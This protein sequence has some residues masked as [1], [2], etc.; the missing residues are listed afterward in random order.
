M[1]AEDSD[2]GPPHASPRSDQIVVSPCDLG[3]IFKRITVQQLAALSADLLM[4]FRVTAPRHPTQPRNLVLDHSDGTSQS[5]TVPAGAGDY[6]VDLSHTYPA[7]GYT[8]SWQDEYVRDTHYTSTT[9][10]WGPMAHMPSV[11]DVDPGT[12]TVSASE[13][14]IWYC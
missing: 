8:T 13:T 12:E 4:V 5:V 3:G 6:V 7:R 10:E 1:W 2:G 9:F 11:P 14:I